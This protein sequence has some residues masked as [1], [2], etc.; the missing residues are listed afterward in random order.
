MIKS[1]FHSIACLASVILLMTLFDI[2]LLFFSQRFAFTPPIWVRSIFLGDIFF[3]AIVLFIFCML[4]LLL[5]KRTLQTFQ[6]IKVVIWIIGLLAG[7]NLILS[8]KELWFIVPSFSFWNSLIFFMIAS[9]VFT[10]NFA[11]FAF[12][13]SDD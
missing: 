7:I 10:I 9:S 12:L 5:A 3:D 13:V 4:I 11:I 8:L 1:I 6:P 2:A